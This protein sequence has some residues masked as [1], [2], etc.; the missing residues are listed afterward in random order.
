[1]RSADNAEE[2]ES[3]STGKLRKDFALR[4]YLRRSFL[5]G[6]YGK[7]HS[8]EIVAYLEI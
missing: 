3:S 1:L 4:S 8:L 2:D 6:E 7:G 5:G